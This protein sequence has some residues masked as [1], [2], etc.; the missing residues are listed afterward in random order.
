MSIDCTKTNRTTDEIQYC[1]CQDAISLFKQRIAQWDAKQSAYAL[2]IASY[3]RWLAE[4]N[5]WKSKTGN[6]SKYQKAGLSED[7]KISGGSIFA[8]TNTQCREC[9]KRKKENGWITSPWAEDASKMVKVTDKYNYQRCDLTLSETPLLGWEN[10]VDDNSNWGGEGAWYK[11]WTCTKSAER[12]RIEIEEYNNAEPLTDPTNPGS[13][14]WKVKGKPTEPDIP[15]INDIV[16]CAQTFSGLSVVNGSINIDNISQ[17]C[18][19]N[20]SNNSTVTT[21]SSTVTTPRST[22]TTPKPKSTTNK[23]LLPGVDNNTLVIIVIIII[24][25]ICMSMLGLFGIGFAFT[26]DE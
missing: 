7:F 20:N 3:N 21:P 12:K 17:D 2:E 15:N 13:V 23:Q 26:S 22:V 16:C 24:I 11:W 14:N 8:D 9:A 25:I 18:N 1:V 6:Y 19:I 4:N 5:D 10:Y